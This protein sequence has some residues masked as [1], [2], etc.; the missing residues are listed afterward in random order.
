M[1]PLW[2]KSGIA[3]E[4]PRGSGANGRKCFL[5]SHL[6]VYA[7]AGVAVAAV[8]GESGALIHRQEAI[9]EYHA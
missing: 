7:S 6:S 5:C 8:L 2:L 4:H 1:T 9:D 3:S